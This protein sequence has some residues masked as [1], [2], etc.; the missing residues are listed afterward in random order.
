M[1][2]AGKDGMVQEPQASP[3]LYFPHLGNLVANAL[4]QP[5]KIGKQMLPLTPSVRCLAGFEPADARGTP[6]LYSKE[7]DGSPRTV[8]SRPVGTGHS[9]L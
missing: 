7:Q 6:P 2:D 5:W 8:P 1:T 3:D 9:D 4:A